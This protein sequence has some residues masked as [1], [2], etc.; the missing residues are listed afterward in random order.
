MIKVNGGDV[1]I[2]LKGNTRDD[3][4]YVLGELTVAIKGVSEVVGIKPIKLLKLIKSYLVDIKELDTNE[5]GENVKK[6]QC[7]C[8]R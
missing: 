2:D 5:E 7:S 8:C 4:V 1:I 6:N 3:K